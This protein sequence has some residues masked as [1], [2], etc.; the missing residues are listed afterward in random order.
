MADVTAERLYQAD[1]YRRVCQEVKGPPTCKE[2]ETKLNVL[3][4]AKDSA[5][6]PTGLVPLA[7]AVQ[8]I[9]KLPAQER[10]ELDALIRALRSLP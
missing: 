7:N 9:G 4:G 5:G 2:M 3:E 8:Q 6:K 1:R 10:A